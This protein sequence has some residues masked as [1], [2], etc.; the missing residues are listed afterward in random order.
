MSENESGFQTFPMQ[1]RPYQTFR[2][3]QTLPR[4]NQSP[5][6]VK[7]LEEL[8][9]NRL[10]GKWL[11]PLVEI[12]GLLKTA[13]GL[14]ESG[15]SVPESWQQHYDV[16]LAELKKVRPELMVT[17]MEQGRQTAENARRIADQLINGCIACRQ[18]P[19]LKLAKSRK[20]NEKKS[21]KLPIPIVSLGNRNYRIGDRTIVAEDAEETVLQAFFAFGCP[22]AKW[23]PL[24]YREL[25]S[26][27]NI[28]NAPRILKK[29][30]TNHPE[31]KPAIECPGRRGRGGLKVY[32]V[33]GN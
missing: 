31:L 15:E 19:P 16:Q 13:A 9:K 6:P 28:E 21:T 23:I 3:L 5:D 20:P 17:F 1:G 22:E 2:P 33:K 29:M 14:R 12:A 26:R 11:N 25:R 4:K 7:L 8:V 10:A 32:L 27:T 18:G 24:S 30:R